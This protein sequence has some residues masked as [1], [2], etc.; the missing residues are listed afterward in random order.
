MDEYMNKKVARVKFVYFADFKKP[1]SMDE[2]MD[3]LG[4]LGD[5]TRDVAD[6]ILGEKYSSKDFSG[7]AIPTYEDEENN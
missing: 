7:M 3:I 4:D 1:I 6:D 2:M 5:K